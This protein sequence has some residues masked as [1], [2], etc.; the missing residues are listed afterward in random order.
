M[1]V[2]RIGNGRP[3][4]QKVSSTVQWVTGVASSVARVRAAGSTHGYAIRRAPPCRRFY[5]K[6]SRL[7]S[8]V[9]VVLALGVASLSLT[10]CQSTGDMSSSGGSSGGSSGSS[11]GY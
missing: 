11:G 3:S 9:F 4:L 8:A 5:M 1:S 2:A 6:V 10:A 7:V